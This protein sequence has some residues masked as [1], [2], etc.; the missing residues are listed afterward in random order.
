MW[1]VRQEVIA[2]S[3]EER[4]LVLLEHL[5]VRTQQIFDRLW[6]DHSYFELRCSPPNYHLNFKTSDNFV[7]VGEQVSAVLGG[8]RTLCN[9]AA[10]FNRKLVA[11][12]AGIFKVVLRKQW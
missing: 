2:E 4:D 3:R 10:D 1:Q 6:C 8:V 5:V 11:L 7:L 12:L 9:G